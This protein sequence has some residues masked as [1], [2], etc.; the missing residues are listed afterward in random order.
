MHRF[1][2]VWDLAERADR[3]RQH[4]QAIVSHR[5]ENQLWAEVALWELLFDLS[6]TWSHP[7]SSETA[8]IPVSVRKAL[9]YIEA[10]LSEPMTAEDVAAAAD[11]SY[12]YLALLFR[13]HLQS[14]VMA[15][16]RTRK[17]TVAEEL[18]RYSGMP[19][20]SVAAQIGISDL[21]HF[22]KLIRNAFGAAPRTLRN[23]FLRGS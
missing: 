20:K 8:R 2:V 18:L 4:F 17:M 3:F 6:V 12:S 5:A 10:N 1:P 9:H 16:V 7:G 15:Y 22:N 14:G 19:I 11:I 21:Q 23:R 13:N